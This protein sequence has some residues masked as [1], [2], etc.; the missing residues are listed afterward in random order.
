LTAPETS[1]RE[2]VRFTTE[3]GKGE[4]SPLRAKSEEQPS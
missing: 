1:R 4:D 2:R 3:V